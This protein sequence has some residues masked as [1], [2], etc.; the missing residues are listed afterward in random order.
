MKNIRTL[1]FIFIVSLTIGSVQAANIDSIE[2][3]NVKNV[4]LQLSQDITL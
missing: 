2:V 1:L 3:A 4:D